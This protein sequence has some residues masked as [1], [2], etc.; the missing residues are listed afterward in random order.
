MSKTLTPR[1]SDGRFVSWLF[2]VKKAKESAPTCEP[3]V[4]TVVTTQPSTIIRVLAMF[5][6]IGLAIGL[7]FGLYSLTEYLKNK[8]QPLSKYE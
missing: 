2:L 8:P 1:D 3:V 6:V 5:G 7:I 4:V